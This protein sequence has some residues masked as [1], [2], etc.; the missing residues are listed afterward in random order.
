MVSAVIT[1]IDSSTTPSDEAQEILNQLRE[2]SGTSMASNFRKMRLQGLSSP[3][4][5]NPTVQDLPKS[6]RGSVLAR[7]QMLEQS[8]GQSP[9][10]TTTRSAKIGSA[11]KNK[12]SP[13]TGY[14]SKVGD[15]ISK[16]TASDNKSNAVESKSSF[17]EIVTNPTPE[18]E[19]KDS[20]PKAGVVNS[21]RS[22]LDEAK[23][24]RAREKR[25]SGF[26]KVRNSNEDSVENTATQPKAT[27]KKGK[28]INSTISGSVER[29]ADM[30]IAESNAMSERRR[31]MAQAKKHAAIARDPETKIGHLRLQTN[32]SIQTKTSSE[33]IDPL[34]KEAQKRRNTD[35]SKLTTSP[36]RL[37][38]FKMAE[39]SM[40]K[41]LQRDKESFLGKSGSNSSYSEDSK[42]SVNTTDLNSEP[43]VLSPKFPKLDEVG[44][45]P[46]I[47]SHESRNSDYIVSP[48]SLPGKRERPHRPTYN[49]F[50][51][52]AVNQASDRISDLS[53]VEKKPTRG[54]HHMDSAK[55]DDN[56]QDSSY[57]ET[58]WNQSKV[59]KEQPQHSHYFAPIVV[60][61]TPN[62]SFDDHADDE[63]QF[64]SVSNSMQDDRKKTKERHGPIVTPHSPGGSTKESDIGSNF[65]V[66]NTSKFEDASYQ[67]RISLHQHLD[68]GRNNVHENDP[69]RDEDAESFTDSVTNGSWTG[70]MRA[71]K[72]ME[73]PAETEKIDQRI[74]PR[75][76]GISSPR[77]PSISIDDGMSVTDRMITTVQR[78]QRD[79]VNDAQ[80]GLNTFA[81]EDPHTTAVGLGVA[82][83]LCGAIVFG[84]IGV[85]LGAAS[86]G[87][88]YKFSQ[89]PE[90]EKSEVKNKATAAMENLRETALN[91]NEKICGN[92]QKDEETDENG[93]AISQ[94]PSFRPSPP[95]T[96]NQVTTSPNRDRKMTLKVSNINPNAPQIHQTPADVSRMRQIRR[97]SPACQRMGRITPVGQIH[98][99]D[100]ALHPRAW[101]DVM[102][103]AW[104]SRE[105]KNE[106]MEEIL[107]LAKDKVSLNQLFVSF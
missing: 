81:S 15:S 6:P 28:E 10:H 21:I 101:L 54:F 78:Q 5:N 31:K 48:S 57:F 56:T 53:S 106:A 14:K 104:T 82:G 17:Q 88:G 103:S 45:L 20:M 80:E 44:G 39:A 90:D 33:S 73:Q 34:D 26:G 27:A 18:L 35:S 72:A 36:G 58:N 74:D 93:L 4:R 1:N 49:D 92:G 70:R 30:A 13:S 83:A 52:P 51:M 95:S 86:A 19:T 75:L 100:P 94:V 97:I 50:D 61:G 16:S 62:L 8:A 69:H 60:E 64:N 89:L 65:F 7:V 77:S 98:S 23:K 12:I 41:N 105:E 40:K 91:A 3:S 84:P 37:R 29:A 55:M 63:T 38:K 46:T 25:D 87:A 32:T 102:S 43:S 71:R 42:G 9:T 22:K 99:L 66:G 76:G 11:V 96:N 85:V 67:N 24:E 79:V 68:K 47:V 107:L 59:G 2:D